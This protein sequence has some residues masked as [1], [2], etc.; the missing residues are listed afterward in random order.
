MKIKLSSFY[1]IGMSLNELVMQLSRLY[2]P[3]VG[4]N[5]I[6]KQPNFFFL[7]LCQTLQKERNCRLILSKIKIKSQNMMNIKTC[8]IKLLN[9]NKNKEKLNKL[10]VREAPPG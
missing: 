5:S 10:K 7:N 1:K 4:F 2:R 8:I 3:N 9:L 6:S